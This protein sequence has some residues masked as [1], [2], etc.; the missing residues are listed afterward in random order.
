MF[1]CPFL[2]TLPPLLPEVKKI[3]ASEGVRRNRGFPT[4][5]FPGT[6][7]GLTSDLVKTSQIAIKVGARLAQDFSKTAGQALCLED[8][9]EFFVRQVC[10]PED[11]AEGSSSKLLVKWDDGSPVPTTKLYV[12]AT[13][14]DLFETEATE[15]LDGLLA[16]YD[17]QALAQAL[18]SRVAMIG[19]S[20]SVG[21]G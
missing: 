12:A 5:I 16:R 10:L 6:F 1:G 17:R 8:G 21:S 9:D 3:H 13:L 11:R 19:G 20:I 7:L 14:T 2:A 4:L 15:C 18:S